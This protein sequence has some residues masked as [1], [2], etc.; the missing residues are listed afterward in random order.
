MSFRVAAC[1]ALCLIAAACSSGTTAVETETAS[2]E[3][4]AP[5]TVPI[6]TGD[7]AAAREVDDLTPAT[8][9]DADT[10][11]ADSTTTAPASTS[12]SAAPAT[13]TTPPTTT[14][15]PTTTA[16][17]TTTVAPTTTT[18]QPPTTTAVVAAPDQVLWFWAPW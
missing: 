16:A 9:E 5:T 14:A 17:P 8:A 18:S 15:T 2:R 10:V 7:P 12:T 3:L 4:A 6:E 1:A 13:T 11:S